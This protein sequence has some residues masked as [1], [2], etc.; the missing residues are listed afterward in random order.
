MGSIFPSKLARLALTAALGW[1]SS[2]CSFLFV[3]GPPSQPQHAPVIDCTTSKVA[4]VLDSVFGVLEVVRIVAAAAASDSAYQ[5]ASIPREADI[6]LG[7]A[8]AAL[9]IGSATY[10]G[11]QTG[12]CAD[13]KEKFVSDESN[14]A[15]DKNEEQSTTRSAKSVASASVRPTASLAP[16][17][18]SESAATATTPRAFDVQA[19]RTAIEKALGVAA[20]SCRSSGGQRVQIVATMT[21]G[22][23]G[24]VSKVLLEPLPQEATVGCV[25]SAL[26]EAI[27]PPFEGEPTAV[28]KRFDWGG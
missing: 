25:A 27:V 15:N 17:A 13:L 9:F 14:D 8:F 2:G 24:R 23:D 1:G 19:A 5:N 7:L 16:T 21:Y 22:T 18:E 20:T 11:I 10:G 6:G 26:R 4:P 28:K 3:K 12:R